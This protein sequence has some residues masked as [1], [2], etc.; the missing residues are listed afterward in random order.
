VKLSGFSPYFFRTVP[1]DYVSARALAD[2]MLNRLQKKTAIVFFNSQSGYSQS[3]KAEFMTALS[4]GGGQALMEVD[5]SDPGFSPAASLKAAQQQGVEV[6]VLA[7]NTGTLDK[8]LQIVEVNRQRLQM[9][10]GDDVYA[11]K[12]YSVFDFW[13]SQRLC[14]T[15]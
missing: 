2:Y 14:A 1:S 10:G 9:L 3:L 11:P 4:L 5:L 13:R 15:G 12:T 6:I 7:A 8:A